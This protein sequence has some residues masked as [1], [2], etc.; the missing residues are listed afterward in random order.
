MNRLTAE[1]N[2]TGGFMNHLTGVLLTAG[3]ILYILLALVSLDR[4]RDNQRHSLGS[5]EDRG[6]DVGLRVVF[7]Q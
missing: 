1:Q 2:S 6:S 3:L 4:T 5:S 7:Q